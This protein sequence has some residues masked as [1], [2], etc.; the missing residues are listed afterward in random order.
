M[1]HL[2]LRAVAQSPAL[3]KL[4]QRLRALSGRQLEQ[5]LGRLTS[6]LPV[7]AASG[8][9]YTRLH[10]Q[11]CSGASTIDKWMLAGQRARSRALIDL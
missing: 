5:T 3:G 6:C 4:T 10:R 9:F 11:S 1:S 2:A 8:R 7:A